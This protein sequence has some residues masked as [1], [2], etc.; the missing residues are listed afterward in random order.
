MCEMCHG[1]SRRQMLRDAKKK[2]DR[3]GWTNISVRASSDG[4]MFTYTAGL[5]Q[6]GHP[7]FIVLGL[8][9]SAAQNLL[10]GLAIAVAGDHHHHFLPGMKVTAEG[11]EAELVQ[12]DRSDNWLLMAEELCGRAVPALQVVWADAD[13][14]FPWQRSVSK[15]GPQQVL[16]TPVP[17]AKVLIDALLSN[18]RN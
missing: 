2:I 7:E 6:F 16:G 10:N 12:V 5:V 8:E 14:T 18:S 1:K 9:P 17:P 4:P 3:F 11:R 15:R 13:G